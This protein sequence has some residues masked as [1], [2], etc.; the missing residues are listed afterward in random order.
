M[1]DQVHIIIAGDRGKVIKVP[2]SRKKIR[3]Y[4]AVSIF[5]LLFLTGTSIFSI[6]YFTRQHYS[7]DEVSKLQRALKISTK[8]QKEL[9]LKIAK[10]EKFAAEQAAAFETEK[11]NLISN[12]INK[13]SKRSELI[14]DIVTSIGIKLPEPKT[15]DGQNSGGLF[16]EDK[17]QEQDDLLLKAD[18]YLETVRF[19]PLG[20]P[21][22]GTISSPYG[23]R[24]D[25]LNKKAAFH[26]GIDFKAKR[27]D[28]ILA[29]ADGVVIKA[30]RNGGYGNYVMIDHGNGYTTSFSHMQKYKVHRGD[31]VKRGQVIGLVGNTGRSTGPHLHYE[32]ALNGK[33]INPYKFMKLAKVKK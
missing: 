15:T 5:V 23:R 27:G 4:A 19:L 22:K 14:E 26:T 33:T 18:K 29:T 7:S 12:A 10:L 9:D 6:S 3:I 8:Q 31:K 30:F 32:V 24:K 25:P 16:I 17:G 20:R 1:D 21:V 2:C 28:K 13:L 11:E